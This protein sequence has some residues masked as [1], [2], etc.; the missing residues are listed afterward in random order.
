MTLMG[1][2]IFWGAM[3]WGKSEMCIKREEMV[4][5]LKLSISVGKTICSAVLSKLSVF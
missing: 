5:L 4:S 1:F 3:F 2:F